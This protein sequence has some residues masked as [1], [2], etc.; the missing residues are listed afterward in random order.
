MSEKPTLLIATAN[1]G[2]L[3]EMRA[4][5]NLDGLRLVSLADLEALHKIEEGSDYAE[6][7]RRKAA[8]F[9]KITGNWTVADDSGL[10]VDALGGAPGPHSARIAG[11]HA[12]DA[13]RRRMLL[14]LLQPHPRPW[15]ARFRCTMALASPEGSV[16]LGVGVCEGEVVPAEAGS[17]GFGYDPIFLVAGRGQTMAELSEADKNRVSHRARAVQ[18]LLPTLVLRLNLHGPTAPI[19]PPAR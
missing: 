12:S 10:E 4:L 7:A 2:K 5:L 9:A 6:N 11:E 13:D 3:R 8:S 19:D 15:T 17:G 1:A 18:A 16:D 14:R